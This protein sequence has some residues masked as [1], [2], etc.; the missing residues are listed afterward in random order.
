MMTMEQP[1]RRAWVPFWEIVDAPVCPV[2][3]IALRVETTR[4]VGAVV[5]QHR[6]CPLCECRSIT[7]YRAPMS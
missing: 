3:K 5:R 2:H 1:R 4:A 6:K 7:T